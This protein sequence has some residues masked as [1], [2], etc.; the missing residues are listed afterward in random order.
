MWHCEVGLWLFVCS[1]FHV[2][3]LVFALMF[4]KN[5][6]KRSVV[7]PQS[8]KTWLHVVCS[9]LPSPYPALVATM[10]N[11]LKIGGWAALGIQDKIWTHVFLQYIDFAA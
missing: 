7:W 2:R 1:C 3:S 5:M 6:R 8:G 11:Q 10:L 9:F 4:T